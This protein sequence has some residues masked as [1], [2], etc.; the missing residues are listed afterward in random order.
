MGVE[1]QTLLF[2][3]KKKILSKWWNNALRE[4][5]IFLFSNE[6]QELLN[7]K[8]KKSNSHSIRYHIDPP[9]S[10]ELQARVKKKNNEI[11]SHK[12][13]S[14][15]LNLDSQYVF[16]ARMQRTFFRIHIEKFLRIRKLKLS[17]RRIHHSIFLFTTRKRCCM[18]FYETNSK[19]LN[20]L[21]KILNW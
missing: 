15:Y 12:K 1:V 4:I 8:R 11:I 14:I 10:D 5:K 16:C 7:Q 20:F 21:R 13:A 18:C 2:Y 17:Y 3:G 19:R 9:R 6:N